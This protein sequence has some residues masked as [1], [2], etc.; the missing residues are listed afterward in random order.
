M[1][2]RVVVVGAGVGGLAAAH[3]LL[4]EDP[5]LEVTVLEADRRP[6]GKL[7][8][9]RVGD[10][11]VEAGPDA[12]VARK[13]WAADLCRELG[14]PLEAPATS[15]SL[16][17]TDRGLL[18]FP[19]N[20][21]GVPASPAELL[22]WPGLPLG[23]R[24]RALRDLWARRAAP[25]GDESLGGLV[26]RRLGDGVAEVLVEPL[27]AGL[28][29]GDA[30]RLSARATFPELAAW[31]R[32]HGSLI[33]GARAALRAARR[34]DPGPV[35]VR[36]AG[37]VRRLVDA[38][39]GAVGPGRI[40]LGAVARAIWAEGAAYAVDA[41]ADGAF[42]A[43]AVLVA[44]PAF[45]AAD[46]LGGIA[47]AAAAALRRIPYV[48]TGVLA[49][50]YPEGTGERLPEA[51]GFVVPRG[52]A[53]MLACTFLSRKWPDRAF[54][55]RAVLRCF[56][57]GAGAEDLLD[58]P[59]DEIVEGV[60]RQLAAVLDLPPLPEVWALVRWP[61]AMPQYEVGHEEL[62]RGVAEALPPGIFVVGPAY[63]GAGVA[64]VV[65]AA[66]EAAAA[67]VAGLRE[68]GAP[69]RTE[70]TWTTS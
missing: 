20:A 63:G 30:D 52:R 64:D 7:R 2:A 51:S 58:V 13:P 59:D 32:D 33:R 1:S 5:S 40:R 49:L 43:D 9:V 46:L 27:L 24:V 18:P 57:G 53:A 3:R 10:L 55:G 15:R 35:F 23:A 45:V 14:V 8:T 44:T 70:G 61:R 19:G 48:S 37:G 60:G 42:P 29:A 54:G 12:F 69:E 28:F 68:R 56:L 39:V 17:W 38:L 66:N 26:R 47:P 67:A 11:E 4:R 36:P 65:R 34:V 21:F 50:A 31:E 6:G 25:R 22:R 16:V 41:G 62:L